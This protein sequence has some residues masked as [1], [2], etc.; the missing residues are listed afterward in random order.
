MRYSIYNLD[1]SLRN[2]V[3]MTYIYLDVFIITNIYVNYFLLKS[4]ARISH[5]KLTLKRCAF[6]SLIGVIP[7]LIILLPQCPMS[8]LALI[9]MASASLVVI[10]AFLKI[11]LSQLIKL[12]A[13][14]FGISFIFSGSMTVIANLTKTSA[15]LV[16]NYTIYFNISIITLVIA[17]IIS[18]CIVCVIA[19]I[20]DRKMNANHCYTVLV[21]FKGKEYTFSGIGDTGNTLV[22]SFSGKPVIICDSIKLA[23]YLNLDISKNYSTSEYMELFIGFKGFRLLP[24]STI[25]N[26][27]IIPAFLADNIVITD[28]NENIKPVDAYIALSSNLNGEENAIFNPRLLI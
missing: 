17:T 27:G 4:T 2:G 7:S 25:G 14:F 10:I 12:T 1:T 11:K 3:D 22:D 6:A 9:K 28:E 16:N 19:L 5:T 15:I 13:I 23:D 8:I 24:Y 20:L 21:S 26:K 18:Y